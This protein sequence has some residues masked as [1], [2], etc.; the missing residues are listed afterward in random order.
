M[1]EALYKITSQISKDAHWRYRMVSLERNLDVVSD[2]GIAEAYGN[3]V[4]TSTR[5]Q[6]DGAGGTLNY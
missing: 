4:R 5:K 1:A 6:D 3:L 2:D